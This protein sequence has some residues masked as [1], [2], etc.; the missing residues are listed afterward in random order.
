MRSLLVLEIKW[1]KGTLMNLIVGLVAGN[2][3][4]STAVEKA[5]SLS[6]FTWE[7]FY[8]PLF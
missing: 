2:Y 5:G 7:K 3:L 6:L 8:K 1:E 4:K